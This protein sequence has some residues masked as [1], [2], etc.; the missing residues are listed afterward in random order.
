M[1][2]RTPLV[3]LLAA[4]TIA[5]LVPPAAGAATRSCGSVGFTPNSDDGAFGIRAQG[6]SCRTARSVAR[7]SR[8][9][10]PSG[11][12][13]DVY[14]YRHRRFRCVGRQRDTGLASVR[15]RC[16]RGSAVVTFSRS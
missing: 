5:A 11:E 10:G 14:R 13:G 9:Y 3:P 7:A 2:R 12:P 6:V 4:L 16:T 8:P 1:R 15:F